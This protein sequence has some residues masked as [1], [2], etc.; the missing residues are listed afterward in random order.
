MGRKVRCL[1]ATQEDSE[2]YRDGT[3][4]WP[5]NL[6]EECLFYTQEDGERYLGGL[7]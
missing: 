3:P 1:A 6:K 5:A 4:L 7:P 2:R